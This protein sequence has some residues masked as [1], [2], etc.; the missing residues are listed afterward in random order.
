MEA[1][2]KAALNPGEVLARI[3]QSLDHLD[4]DAISRADA[5]CLLGWL[6][7]ARRVQTRVQGVA[8]TLLGHAQRRRAAETV[9]GAPVEA[10]LGSLEPLSRR[11]AKGDVRR[12]QVL[13][14]HPA[15]GKSVVDGRVNQAQAGAIGKV[16]ADL[17]NKLDD[18]QKAL[19][20]DTLIR[21]AGRY[22][23]DALRRAH[24]EVLR[25]VAPPDE[26]DRVLGEHL[27]AEAESARK[28]MTFH[29]FKVNSRVQFSGSLPQVEGEMWLAQLQAFK[30]ADRR[31]ALDRRDRVWS[32]LTEE[33]KL[34]RALVA[35]IKARAGTKPVAGVG[36][37]TLMVTVDLKDLVHDA[38]GAGVIVGSGARLA[39]G[40]LRRMCCTANILPVVMGG[41]SKVLD[42]GRADRLASEPIRRALILRDR[43]CA[44]PGC[45]APPEACE[46]HHIVPW[47]H[48]GKT[49]L[50]NLVLLCHHHHG[51]V[52]PDRFQK[53]DQWEVR[54]AA[55]GV[56][57]FIPPLRFDPQQRSRR[58]QRYQ[59]LVADRGGGTTPAPRDQPILARATEAEGKYPARPSATSVPSALSATEGSTVGVPAASRSSAKAVLSPPNSPADVVPNRPNSPA[60]VVPNRPMS[61]AEVVLNRP[62][63]PADSS[64][65]RLWEEEIR[66]VDS[67]R[68]LS[69]RPDDARARSA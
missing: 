10:W 17:E 58:H 44:F 19:A 61:P 59:E 47:Y 38:A 2:L 37:A 21:L 63:S 29:Y 14:Q 49:S 64:H 66:P 12:A 13:D 11:Q 55:D 62:E 51:I 40:D 8:S 20:E 3:S 27:A 42:L 60:D 18:Q 31:E 16:L 68:S 46:A 34:G 45:D 33:Q 48:G 4:L 57:E 36:D 54:I 26:A 28:A 24:K 9:T 39:P 25:A 6:E 67:A 53:R 15:T 22:D 65:P 7:Q 50:I 32:D 30:E 5:A 43:G 1:I 69:R 41:P 23:A 35:Q 52:E 56:P